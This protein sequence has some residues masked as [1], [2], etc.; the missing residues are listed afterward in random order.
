M[1]VP[2]IL[3]CKS[4]DSGSFIAV[5]TVGL[6][7]AGGPP[8]DTAPVL[9]C[10]GK[11]DAAVIGATL[12]VPVALASLTPRL[13]AKFCCGS[14]AIKSVAGCAIFTKS[15]GGFDADSE[16]GVGGTTAGGLLA[17][18]G[19]AGGATSTSAAGALAASMLRV[20]R[21][22]TGMATASSGRPR[23]DGVACSSSACASPTK[24]VRIASRRH[25]GDPVRLFM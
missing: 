9:A 7:L 18:G 16:G 25:G 8:S 21:A 12:G 15:G 20:V 1:D 24:A 17:R 5:T 11:L 3:Y 19:G 10:V 14:L 23:R 13:V 2:V 6:G 22:F 4:T